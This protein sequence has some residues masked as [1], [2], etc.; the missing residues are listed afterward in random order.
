MVIVSKDVSLYWLHDYDVKP[1]VF[2]RLQ[3][4]DVNLEDLLHGNVLDNS[5]YLT[6]KMRDTLQETVFKIQN[7]GLLRD[8]VVLLNAFGIPG[9]A[10][11]RIQSIGYR[12]ISQLTDDALITILSDKDVKRS[13]SIQQAMKGL[14]EAINSYWDWKKLNAIKPELAKYVTNTGDNSYE[15]SN[16]INIDSVEIKKRIEQR[17]AENAK[18]KEMESLKKSYKRIFGVEEIPEGILEFLQSNIEEKVKTVLIGRI[19]GET[20][21]DIAEKIGVTRERVRQIERNIK[22]KLPTFREEKKLY[23]I[24]SQF[25][26]DDFEFE[27]VFNLNPIINKFINWKYGRASSPAIKLIIGSS[28]ISEEVKSEVLLHS[29][30]LKTSTGEFVPIELNVVIEEVLK[31]K[32]NQQFDINI[33]SENL[34]KYVLENKLPK[35]LIKT[36]KELSKLTNGHYNNVING[37]RGNFRY[38]DYGN[39]DDEAID[40]LNELLNV[41]PGLYGIDFFFDSDAELMNKLRVLNASELANLYKRLGF[42]KFNNLNNILRQSQVM[43]KIDSKNDFIVRLIYD[44][45]KKP[46]DNLI[47]FFSDSYGLKKPTMRALLL[48]DYRE[49]ITNEI[50]VSN[51]SLPMDPMFYIDAKALL[52]KQFYERKEFDSIIENIDSTV[53]GT[54]LLYKKLGYV[55]RGQNGILIREEYRTTQNAIDSMLFEDDV[56]DLS[57][58]YDK[59]NRYIKFRIYDAELKHE[60]IQFSEEKYLTGN[61]L[62]SKGI[63]KQ[64]LND[65]VQKV[66]EYVPFNSFFTFKTLID[67]GFEHELLNLGFN[68]IFYERLIF[69]APDIR[70]LKTVGNV[71]VKPE[72]TENYTPG[73]ADF[74]KYIIGD[75]TS[76]DVDDLIYEINHVYGVQVTQERVLEKFYSSDLIYSSEMRK[77]Y[78]SQSA[79]LDDIYK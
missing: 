39:I 53:T 11:K 30:M 71:F 46:L 41:E 62:T 42:D 58:F 49:F 51:V 3:R 18:R 25:Y 75:S 16:E 56:L 27:K 35:E 55:E 45:D 37:V 70:M 6:N 57:K 63:S 26:F 73:L 33:L 15:N 7:E 43:V 9:I 67:S 52:T 66:L 61:Y 1:S 60:L 48:N 47:D 79:M 40:Q 20:L 12:Q 68:D 72:E 2:Q 23:P 29:N 65:Y 5:E 14:R 69:T 31:E 32:A 54:S 24:L 10:I 44:F 64:M 17:K 4:N 22:R 36:P 78:V 74:V 34:A 19:A 38:F 28:R 8:S 13:A 76:I 77:V 59:K 21:Q 50:I